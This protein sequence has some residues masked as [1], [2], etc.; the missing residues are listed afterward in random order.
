MSPRRLFN[1]GLMALVSCALIYGALAAGPPSLRADGFCCSG[2]GGQCGDSL[3]CCPFL[4]L[5]GAYPC[6]EDAMHYC[7]ESCQLN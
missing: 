6:S 2:D 3:Q 7:R 5:E 4:D 1:S